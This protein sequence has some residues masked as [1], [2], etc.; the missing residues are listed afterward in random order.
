MIA[1]AR[2]YAVCPAAAVAW[3]TLLDWVFANA[4]VT[5]EVFD[6]PAPQP[7]SALWARPDLACTFMCGY[8]FA[9]AATRP[10]LLAAPVPSPAPYGERPVYWTEIVVA[11]TASFERIEDIFG[12]R[13]AWTAEDS[14]SG[15]HAPR[16]LLAPH[17]QRRGS[18]LFSTTVG[19]LVTPREVALAVPK[20]ARTRV[21]STA[22]RSRSCACTSP[23]LGARLRVIAQTPATPI[24]PLVGAARLDAGAARRLRSAL[25][26]SGAAPALAATRAS[27][28]LDSFAVVD[29]DDYARLV[30]DARAADALGYPRIA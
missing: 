8:P 12:G 2:M 1:S 17:A 7:L 14:Q 19:P 18:P 3:R 21:R 11:A 25:L 22:T 15:W 30:A 26:E 16:L 13:F 20:G 4:G 27:L 10:T 23:P 6:Y 24:P 9:T 29:A 5:G 28:L